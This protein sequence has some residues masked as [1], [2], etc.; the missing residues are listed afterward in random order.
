MSTAQTGQSTTLP[1][2]DNTLGALYIGSSLATALYGAICIQTFLY[3]TSN[4]TRFDSWP[5]KL[6]VFILFCSGLDTAHQFLMLAGM[7][8]F[9]ITDYANPVALPTGGSTSS[10]APVI[11]DKGIVGISTILLVQLFF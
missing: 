1:A 6:L 4:R 8:H 3:V 2:F 11:Y 9:L 5:M 7:Y 10:E